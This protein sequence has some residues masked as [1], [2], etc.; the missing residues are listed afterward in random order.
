MIDPVSSRIVGE[1]KVAY[2]ISV[3]FVI[4]LEKDAVRGWY[5]LIRGE[6][7]S[8][9]MISSYRFLRSRVA[10]MSRIL[11]QRSGQIGQIGSQRY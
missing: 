9:K 7:D 3:D 4:E 10:V 2:G 6:C 5:A 8:M 11:R 1:R